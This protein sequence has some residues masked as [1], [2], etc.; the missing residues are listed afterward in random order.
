M[1]L[2]SREKA[3]LAARI[4]FYFAL[5]SVFNG[6][7]GNIMLDLLKGM[8]IV[9]SFAGAC[10]AQG[11][12]RKLCGAENIDMG[13]RAWDFWVNAS[14]DLAS[15]GCGLALMRMR[16]THPYNLVSLGHLM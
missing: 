6:L 5:T 3:A 15:V 9:A 12:K 1:P 14:I 4:V 16:S 2:V 11:V 10:L 7:A 13:S 8:P